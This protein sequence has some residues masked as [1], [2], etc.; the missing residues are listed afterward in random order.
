MPK[1]GSKKKSPEEMQELAVQ[2]EIIRQ[3]INNIDA[4]IKEL[5][6]RHEDLELVKEGVTGIK[7]KA[8]SEALVP[9]G[10]G[11]Y[12]KGRITDGKTCLV[13]IGANVII[14]KPIDEALALIKKQIEN[15]TNTIVKLNDNAEQLV[16]QL[17]EIEPLLMASNYEQ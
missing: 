6:L 7:G 1:E 12:V 11:V 14:E 2:Y 13:N 10:A 3:E 5:Q 15:M 9:V 4:Q 16:G 8:E 17:M